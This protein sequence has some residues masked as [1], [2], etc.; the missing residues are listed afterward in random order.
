MATALKLFF[1]VPLPLG[2]LVSA[3]AVIPLVTHGISWISRFQ[4][5]T[6]PLWIG[7]NLLPVGFIALARLRRRP[8]LDAFGG[9]GGAGRGGRLRPPEI[10]RRGLRHP[11][12]DAA[13]R[14]AGGRAALPPRPAGAGAGHAGLVVVAA[15]GRPG[16]DRARRPKAAV[17]LAARRD[18]AARRRVARACRRSG[19]DVPHRLRPRARLARGRGAAHRRLR[20][21][22]AAEDQRHERLCGLARLVE[23]LLA[24]HPFASRAA[25]SGWC[26]TSPS[27]RC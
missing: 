4:L 18:G 14:R 19:R 21:G 11:G 23:L 26:S 15:R 2:Y 17:R 7:L 8:R 27:R 9:L 1:G 5:L 22:V 13:D 16:L 3:L 6:Q 20:G 10:R 24:P 12:P 25:W